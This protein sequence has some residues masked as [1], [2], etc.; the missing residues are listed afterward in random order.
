MLIQN[1]PKCNCLFSKKELT[2]IFNYESFK[3]ELYIKCS[4]NEKFTINFFFKNCNYFH[5]DENEINI[6][7][8]SMRPFFITQ[9]IKNEIPFVYLSQKRS[10]FLNLVKLFNDLILKSSTT[11]K[12]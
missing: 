6:L 4:E 2:H 10:V 8:S 3:V 1:S 11:G 5:I 7:M 9:I 12:Q